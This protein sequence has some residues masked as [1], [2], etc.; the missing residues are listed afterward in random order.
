MDDIL[1]NLAALLQSV[2]LL[3]DDDDGGDGDGDP[4]NNLA[5][6][7]DT[8]VAILP[9]VFETKLADDNHD[10]T[11]TQHN[12]TD[13]SILQMEETIRHVRDNMDR[14]TRQQL[15][16]YFQNQLRLYQCLVE[17]CHNNNI[18]NDT[19]HEKWIQLVHSLG[20]AIRRQTVSTYKSLRVIDTFL[21]NI[22]FDRYSSPSN[23][24]I[25]LRKESY[26][27]R[28]RY[29]TK[30]TPP[31]NTALSLVRRMAI[32]S[33]SNSNDHHHH[34]EEEEYIPT[35]I[36]YVTPFQKP[37]LLQIHQTPTLNPCLSDATCLIKTMENVFNTNNN[38]NL[39]YR[40]HTCTFLLVGS[41]GTGKTFLFDDIE[42][43]LRQQYGVHVIRPCLPIDIL[44][45][46]IGAAEDALISMVSYATS[47]AATTNTL[48]LLDDIDIL[49]GR[50][51]TTTECQNGGSG[52]DDD[53]GS[54][55]SVPTYHSTAR[56]FSLF[57]DLLD[58]I[59]T[60]YSNDEISSSSHSQFVLVCSTKGNLNNVMKRFDKVFYLGLPNKE[61]RRQLIADCLGICLQNG[62]D[63][64][65]DTMVDC[66]TGLSRSEVADL[67]R[68]A[69]MV[70]ST[71]NANQLTQ[72]SHTL[73]IMKEQL[74]LSIPQSLKQGTNEDFADM[75][76]FTGR[77]LREL[78][79]IQN[80]EDPINDLPLFGES[81]KNAWNE[82]RRLIVMP[83]CEM[84]ALNELLF[85]NTDTKLGGHKSAFGG[86]GVLL[87][88][89]PGTGKSILAYFCAAFA[90][91]FNPSIKL[92]D[93][94]CTSLIHKEVGGSERALHR[95]FKIAKAS[96]PCI[97]LMDGIENIAAVR[98]NDNT[99]EGTMDRLLSTLLT[100][101]DGFDNDPPAAAD[102]ELSSGSSCL[103][104]I[105]MTHDH[106]W[107]DPALR[108]PG[109]LERVIHLQ[110]PERDARKQI[111]MR[112]LDGTLFDPDESTTAPIDLDS[113]ADTVAAETKGLSGARVVAVCNEAK[114]HA[115]KKYFNSSKKSE[116]PR[117]TVGML[118][119]AIQDQ[120]INT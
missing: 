109:R 106:R 14:L 66:T 57:M 50:E 71:S 10:T 92:L 32:R 75:K 90:A 48:L 102:E 84:D 96:T 74:Q 97:L 34:Q 22:Y 68:R 77:D 28:Q 73:E 100:E 60:R 87:A 20:N 7:I 95:V 120:C 113:V 51:A 25:L 62:P 40:P 61:E 21:S 44:G 6:S 19:S 76:V 54:G 49:L 3:D 8:L 35:R 41:E 1:Q 117:L 56:L 114:L 15:P 46:T 115:L 5:N 108:R 105:G 112:E 111:V 12:D 16:K 58:V 53:V 94:S 39:S 80:R 24:Q 37:T 93:V 31:W 17:S 65:L 55:R 4:W 2:H 67:C 30:T 72:I 104:M 103:A 99:T 101:L 11:C 86:A 107:I 29:I 78:F 42:T 118:L 79:P 26:R 91:L 98:G 23:T 63:P 38:N 9:R 64:L 13:L 27:I 52:V 110:Y 88:S 47:T 33:V 18:N 81:A 82:L 69:I 119:Q 70:S 116:N 45:Q 36:D 43:K 59:E 85:C 89:A 83:I